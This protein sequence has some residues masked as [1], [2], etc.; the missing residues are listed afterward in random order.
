MTDTEIKI[1]EATLNLLLK[2]GKFGVSMQEIAEKSKV[3]RSVIH[4]YFRSKEQL[5][6]LVDAEIV[7]RL[8]IPRY[9]KL[10]GAAPLRLKIEQFLEEFE[11]TTKVYPYVDVYSVTEFTN[12][13]AIR[14]YFLSINPAIQHLLSEITLAIQDNTLR[15]SDPVVFLVDLFSLS[16]YSSICIDFVKKNSDLLGVD[17]GE[18]FAGN[19][20]ESIKKL[21]LN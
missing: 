12:S 6:S 10:F 13:A 11:R 7:E 3:S 9:Q 19:R 2:E 1:K 8:L 5:L 15:C 4:Y 17:I 16:T 20:I 21:I 14:N 18:N